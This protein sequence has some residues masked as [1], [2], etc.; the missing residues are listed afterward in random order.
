MKTIP[1]E[2]W[3]LFAVKYALGCLF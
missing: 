1:K 3:C 2:K